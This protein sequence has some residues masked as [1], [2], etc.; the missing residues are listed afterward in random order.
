M[1]ASRPHSLEG[2]V[3][4]PQHGFLIEP[5][6]TFPVSLLP[7]T[8]HILLSRHI[9]LVTKPQTQGL[10]FRIS[11]SLHMILFLLSY[12]PSPN[13]H[14]SHKYQLK[15]NFFWKASLTTAP[16]YLLTPSPASSRSTITTVCSRDTRLSFCSSGS[17]LIFLYILSAWY[18]EVLSKCFVVL[19]EF[20]R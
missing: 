15:S 1:N 12:L 11:L 14:S 18:T 8:P 19:K 5:Q 10:V 2:T 9:K 7:M 13:S 6:I 3:C 4:I 20:T 17:C 16:S